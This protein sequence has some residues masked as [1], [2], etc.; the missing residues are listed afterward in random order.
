M[1]GLIPSL[2]TSAAVVTLI[3]A[4]EPTGSSADAA[5]KYADIQK[6]YEVGQDT[7]SPDGRF[8]ILY[9][10]REDMEE[11]TAPNLLVR[12]KPYKV[13]KDFGESAW[14]G[15]RGEP[16]ANWS[17]DGRFVAVWHA[18]KWGNEDLVVYEIAN[19]QI[20]REEK[21]WPEI[22]RYFGRG[23]KSD[24][25]IGTFVNNDND[26]LAFK[27]HKLFIKVSVDS[28]PNL[29]DGPHDTAELNGVW[30]LETAKFDKVD[31]KRGK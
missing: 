21:I 13:L 24:D 20:K 6:G 26:W 25:A 4:Q 10:I 16:D 31:F 12:L 30:N 3:C 23:R 17:K 1:K 15:M 22:L 2:A 19:D 5:Q 29:V 8:A 14:R 28:Q 18:K 9:P 7:I 27:D 11:T